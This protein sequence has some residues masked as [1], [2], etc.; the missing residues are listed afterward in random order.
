MDLPITEQDSLYPNLSEMSSLE[1]LKAINQEDKK[2]AHVVEQKLPQINDLVE[3]VVASIH[4]GG[5]LFYIGAG[6]SGRLGILDASECPPTYGVPFDMVQGIIAG[7]DSAIR[8]AVEF[9]EDNTEAA[10]A[11]LLQA[12]AKKGDVV[13]GLSASGKTPYVMGGLEAARKQGLIT[14]CI[15]CNIKT[16]IAL[17]SDVLI[18][19]DLGPEVVTGSTRMKSGTAQKMILNMITTASM[20]KLGKVKGSKMFNMQLS[21][22]KLVDRG[23]RMVM[24]ATQLDYEIAKSLLLKHGSVEKV[25]T[26]FLSKS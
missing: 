26:E 9:A 2:I 23:V 6:T 1:I 15:C 24:E 14:A 3:H 21:N 7:G 22:H 10:I 25:V 5:T 11:D 20:V 16:P 4:H 8:K 18:E 13:V 19:L 12:G 17:H